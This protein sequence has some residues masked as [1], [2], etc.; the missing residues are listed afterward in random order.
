MSRDTMLEIALSAEVDE[1]QG[2]VKKLKSQLAA[3]LRCCVFPDCE[4]CE[5][6][7][8]AL[9]LSTGREES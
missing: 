6:S 7:R 5:E 3:Q 2:T 4:V 9:G 8:A 1:L